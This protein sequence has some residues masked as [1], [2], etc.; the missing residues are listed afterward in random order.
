MYTET[1]TT[2]LRKV[3]EQHMLENPRQCP[4]CKTHVAELP[5]H[6]PTTSTNTSAKRGIIKCIRED[7]AIASLRED[8]APG[9]GLKEIKDVVDEVI[10][11]YTLHIAKEDQGTSIIARYA[12][13]TAEGRHEFR[14]VVLYPATQDR[15]SVQAFF[16]R[17][18]PALLNVPDLI[19]VELKCWGKTLEQMYSAE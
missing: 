3:A 10:G 7:T 5:G 6:G 19:K 2:L 16:Y 13:E 11:T 17:N 12:Y 8:G 1:F 18:A 4:Y 14:D 9:F 15:A